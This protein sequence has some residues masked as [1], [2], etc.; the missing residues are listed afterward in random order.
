M[1]LRAAGQTAEEVVAAQAAAKEGRTGTINTTDLNRSINSSNSNDGSGAGRFSSYSRRDSHTSSRSKSEHHAKMSVH[2][3]LQLLRAACGTLQELD[4]L[5][6]A[7]RTST[8]R[9]H[10][11]AADSGGGSGKNQ[12]TWSSFTTR[13]TPNGDT[14]GPARDY[15]PRRRGGKRD[16]GSLMRDGVVEAEGDRAL[17]ANLA[18][19]CVSIMEEMTLPRGGWGADEGEEGGG[20]SVRSRGYVHVMEREVERI[21]REEKVRYGVEFKIVEACNVNTY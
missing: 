9:T 21:V 13:T 7:L 17:R 2:A 19:V 5:E 20:E 16:H 15:G 18:C 14:A 6:D 4:A 12:D 3:R 11:H 8:Q 10:G 1:L